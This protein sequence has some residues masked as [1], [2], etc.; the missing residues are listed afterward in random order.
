VPLKMRRYEILE[1]RTERKR[2]YQLDRAKEWSERT[3]NNRT[4]APADDIHLSSSLGYNKVRPS[5]VRYQGPV[6]DDCPYIETTLK[7]KNNFK[8]LR[9]QNFWCNKCQAEDLWSTLKL[10]VRPNVRRW[11]ESNRPILRNQAS[12]YLRGAPCASTDKNPNA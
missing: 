9:D 6:D 3:T 1:R 8:L 4:E 7:M 2:A 11:I 5:E 10:G 12:T